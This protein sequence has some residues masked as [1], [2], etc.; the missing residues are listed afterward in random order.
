MLCKVIE[1]LKLNFNKDMHL[2]GLDC[3]LGTG[4]Y[5]KEI[6][7]NF[8]NC[9]MNCIEV[10]HNMLELAKEN[11]K[12]YK[13]I[14]YYRAWSDEALKEFEK[15]FDFIVFDL[16]LS[17]LHY[18]EFKRGFTFLEDQILDMR[19]DKNS[20]LDVLK[21][22]NTY[23]L[24]ELDRIIRD[25]GQESYHYKI[26]KAIVKK[27]DE[28]EIKTSFEL[29]DLIEKIIVKKN[30]KIHCATKTFQALRIHVNNEL[31]RLDYSIKIALDLLNTG[32]I[33]IAVSFHSLED[34]I[35]KQNFKDHFNYKKELFQAEQFKV[36]N[37]RKTYKD[38]FN[39]IEYS[40]KP[41]I[42]SLNEL[43]ENRASRSGKLRY[44]RILK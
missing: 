17:T 32:G 18:K 11:L 10:D 5:T 7:N 27:R 14:S 23:P 33:I 20:N 25:Y 34:K 22:L 30:F 43:K 21:V 38:K 1:L 37:K 29:V 41:L 31:N 36:T 44:F 8:K 4:G 16:G 42:P 6:L 13:N 19:L 35:I 24:Q 3:N 26:A 12:D 28:K 15:G 39:N 40:K 9:S 2:R